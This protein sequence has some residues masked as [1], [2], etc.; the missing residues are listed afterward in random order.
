MKEITN[1]FQYTCGVLIVMR[2]LIN[3]GKCK[4]QLM[5]NGFN[6]LKVDA[7]IHVPC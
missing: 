3:Y 2:V 4:M 7:S 1:L 5:S 6:M